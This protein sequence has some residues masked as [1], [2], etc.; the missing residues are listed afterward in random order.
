MNNV[1]LSPIPFDQLKNELLELFKTEL[2]STNQNKENS[3]NDPILT[4]VKAAKY[5]NLS[6]PTFD[7]GTNKGNIPCFRINGGSKKL[8]RLSDLDK[9]L[10]KVKTFQ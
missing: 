4:R 7:K 10:V 2:S 5:L 3:P 9:C 8:Y 1:I 6:L